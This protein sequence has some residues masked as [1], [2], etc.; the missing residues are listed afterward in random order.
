MQEQYENRNPLETAINLLYIHK[1]SFRTLQRTL[2]ASSRKINQL[3]LFKD[4][5]A[6]YCKNHAK[7]KYKLWTKCRVFV[8]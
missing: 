3:M 6:L 1:Y 8:A 7:H 5:I 4:I 2:C